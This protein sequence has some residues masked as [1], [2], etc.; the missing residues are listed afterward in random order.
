MRNGLAKIVGFVALFAAVAVVVAACGGGG[1]SSSSE[2]STSEETKSETGGSESSSGGDISIDVGSKKIELPAGTEPNIAWFGGTGNTYQE[3]SKEG[4]EAKAGEVGAKVTW[5]DGKYSPEVQI[6]LLQNALATG[7][8]NVWVFE[9]YSGEASCSYIKK[10]IEKGIV[11]VQKSNFTCGSEQEAA[12]ED[13]W[14]DGTLATVGACCTSTYYDSFGNEVKKVIEPNAEAGLLFGPPGVVATELLSAGVNQAGI[15]VAEEINTGYTTPEGLAKTQT[16]LQGNP[17]MTVV[18]SSFTDLTVG[19]VRAIESSGK[20][21][22]I[23]VF[24]LGGSKVDKKLIEEGKLVS[25]QPYFPRSES[26]TAVEV[27]AEAFE[28]KPVERFESGFPEGTPTKPYIVTKENVSE[29][30]PEY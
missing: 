25:T 5:F 16:M 2:A 24:D 13:A 6:P 29:F 22:E 26:E 19:I 18:L 7:D 20:E 14:L 15:N 11:V 28:G 21:D 17:D 27:V 4:A 1:S 8:F 12:N 23:E 9:N 30:N 3:A 10:A